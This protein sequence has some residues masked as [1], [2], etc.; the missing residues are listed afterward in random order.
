[1]KETENIDDIFSNAM[2]NFG[3]EPPNN[4]QDAIAEKRGN[5]DPEE[6]NNNK[7]YFIIIIAAMAILFAALFLLNSEEQKLADAKEKLKT[8]N[9]A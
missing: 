7:N 5:I 9:E 4:L 1:M 2:D 3:V 6:G 8:K